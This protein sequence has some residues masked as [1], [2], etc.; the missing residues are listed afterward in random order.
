MGESS[1]DDVCIHP[2]ACVEK[3]AQ[4]GKGVKI[5]PFSVIGRDVIIEDGVEVGPH[6]VIEGHTVIKKGAKIAQFASIGAAPQDLK[7]AGEPTRVEIGEEAVIREFVSVHRGTV[8]GRGVTHVGAKCLVMA[9]C[10]IA[11]DCDVGDGVIMANGATFGG[12]VQVGDHVVIGGLSAV[13]QFCRIGA[14]AFLGGMSGVDKDIPPFTK[15]WGM[16]G[17]LYGLNLVGIRR[18]GFSADVIQGLRQAYRTVFQTAPTLREGLALAEKTP[19]QP[20]E[21]IQF[22]EFIRS[23]KRG[24]PTGSDE[25]TDETAGSIQATDAAS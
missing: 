11:H 25:T 14:Y 18:K 17:K 19:S 1:L 3:A 8:S 7:Y 15:Y 22:L 23:S 12:H 20:S 9:Y 24:I 2:L 5:G 13:H 4:I 21:V 10:H 16:R 6:V